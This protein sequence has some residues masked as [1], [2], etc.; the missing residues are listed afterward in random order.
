MQPVLNFAAVQFRLPKNES[1]FSNLANPAFTIGEN[2]KIQSQN[3]LEE[4]GAPSGSIKNNRDASIGADQFTSLLKNRK[5]HFRH[6][7]VRLQP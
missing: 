7:A 5:E 6:S 4:L 2:V 1:L 3:F